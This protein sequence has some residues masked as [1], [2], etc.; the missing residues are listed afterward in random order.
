M[1]VGALQIMLDKGKE[2]GWFDSGEIVALGL[3]ALVGF[4]VFLVWELT[5]EHPVVDLRLFGR[6]NF[7]TGT[8]A[9]S[10]GYGLFFGNVVLLPMWLQQYMGYTASAAGMAVAPVGLLAILL[11]PL[12]GKNVAKVDPRRFATVAF[13]GFAFVLWMRSHFTVQADF[14]TIMVPTI[15]QGGAIAFFFIPLSAITLNGLT[16]DRIPSASG[17]T[18]FVRITAGAMGTSAVT[19]LWDNRATLHHV[20]MVEKLTPTDPATAEAVNG[21][22][23]TGMSFEQAVA[24]ITRLIDQQ[25]FTRAADDVYLGSAILFLCLVPLIWLSR[26]QRMGAAVDAGGA[27]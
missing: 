3:V 13:L 25:A 4:V 23:G 24:Q 20:H 16:P 22:M 11:S 18:N 21:L 1:W 7:A 2:L 6:R 8:V 27:H 5:A 26:P 17:L 12:V 10:I 14:A 9:T 19:T 15:L